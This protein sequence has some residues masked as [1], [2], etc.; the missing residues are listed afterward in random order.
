[1]GIEL[2]EIPVVKKWFSVKNRARSRP[3]PFYR[4]YALEKPSRAERKGE[5]ESTERKCR[6]GGADT[7][8]RFLT[9]ILISHYSDVQTLDVGLL[10]ANK[11][12]NLMI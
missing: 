11:V 6:V 1:M 10:A 5:K 4:Q 3:D 2:C 8:V 7:V 12:S 9:E